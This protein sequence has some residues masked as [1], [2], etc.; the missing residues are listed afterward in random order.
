VHKTN[1]ITTILKTNTTIIMKREDVIFVCTILGA[2]TAVIGAAMSIDISYKVERLGKAAERI[3]DN[4][5]TR[6][7]EA[8]TEQRQHYQ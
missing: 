3:A 1:I 7:Q 5:K 6:V 4:V 8:R 2:I